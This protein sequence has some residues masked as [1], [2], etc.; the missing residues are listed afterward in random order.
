MRG[1]APGE[2]IGVQLWGVLAET[3]EGGVS[4]VS[5]RR[6]HPTKITAILYIVRISD[7]LVRPCLAPE[8]H[9]KRFAQRLQLVETTGLPALSNA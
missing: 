1:E 6:C 9:V 5:F 3:T 4:A 8:R 2:D 7:D